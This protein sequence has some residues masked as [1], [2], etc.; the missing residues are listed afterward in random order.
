MKFWG[1]AESSSAGRTERGLCDSLDEGEASRPEL[2]ACLLLAQSSS[3]PA[4]RASPA[5]LVGELCP[6]RPHLLFDPSHDVDEY[7]M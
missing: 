7:F 2:V 3:T 5:E 6:H 4:N 1:I